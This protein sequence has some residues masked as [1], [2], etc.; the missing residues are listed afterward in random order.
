MFTVLTGVGYT[1]RRILSMLPQGSVTGLSR[2]PRPTDESVL[3]FDLDTATQL[4][5]QG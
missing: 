4:R 2:S 3:A 1:G 5:F